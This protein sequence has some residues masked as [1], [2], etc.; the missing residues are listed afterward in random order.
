MCEV[1]IHQSYTPI[2]CPPKLLLH[3]PSNYMWRTMLVHYLIYLQYINYLLYLSLFNKIIFK[4]NYLFPLVNFQTN[5]KVYMSMYFFNHKSTIFILVYLLVFFP[6]IF[7]W[8][9]RQNS[10]MSFYVCPSFLSCCPHT[11]DLFLLLLLFSTN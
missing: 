11:M 2:N 5:S 10:I 7:G 4:I 6:I 3:R 8:E 9:F 1:F